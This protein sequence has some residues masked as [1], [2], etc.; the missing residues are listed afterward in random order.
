MPVQDNLDLLQRTA[1]VD[2]L[3]C[4]FIVSCSERELS[5][6]HS[7]IPDRA[8]SKTV[9]MLLNAYVSQRIQADNKKNK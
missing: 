3:C 1:M 8:L 4:T 6:W 2:K 9:R 7:Y 5:T